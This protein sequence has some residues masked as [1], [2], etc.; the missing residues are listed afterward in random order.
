MKLN[1]AFHL[2]NHS[3]DAIDVIKKHYHKLFDMQQFPYKYSKFDPTDSGLDLVTPT[4][5]T[6]P[7]GTFGHLIKT[8]IKCEIVYNGKIH[9]YDI[10]PRS[11]I[12]KTPIRMS[13][14]IGTI[15]YSYRGELMVA[16]DNFSNNDHTIEAGTCL[17]QLVGPQLEPITFNIV[18]KLSETKRGQQGFGSTGN[19]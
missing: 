19:T 10:R 17:F 2:D 1:L 4:T 11:S 8:G 14:S 15:D 13:N 12:R 5:V 3:E 16:V 9:G 18:D 6:I 7:S